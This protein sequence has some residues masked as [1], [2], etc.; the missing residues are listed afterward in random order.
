MMIITI[1]LTLIISSVA[2]GA[3]NEI[4]E[5]AKK[6][7]IN[8]LTEIVKKDENGEIIKEEVSVDYNKLTA[9]ANKVLLDGK[10][11]N[12][13]ISDNIG[14][15]TVRYSLE[16]YIDLIYMYELSETETNYINNLIKNGCEIGKIVEIYYFL[17]NCEEDY[18]YIDKIYD[19]GKAI[20]FDDKY[21]IYSAYNSATSE[22]HGLIEPEELGQ[23]IKSGVSEEDILLAIE[24][25]RNGDSKLKE[26]LERRT[27]K[28]KWAD[29]IKSSHKKA[30]A[31]DIMEIKNNDDGRIILD[32]INYSEITKMSINETIKDI[33]DGFN[34]LRTDDIINEKL[35]RAKGL[36]ESLDLSAQKK[37]GD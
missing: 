31:L 18:T 2:F 35:R 36:M 19:I 33:E 16:K 17:A 15:E 27:K 29:I 6:D 13:I 26:I 9:S 37:I 14:E 12:S 21:W 20:G 5:A 34:N 3:I 23:F 32:G 28:H 11:M 25:S 8:E 7:K 1:L 10:L 22:K 30:G 24:V 4:M